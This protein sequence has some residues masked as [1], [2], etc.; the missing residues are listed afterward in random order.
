MARAFASDLTPFRASRGTNA[1]D[2]KA[3]VTLVAALFGLVAFSL[4]ALCAGRY[5]LTPDDVVRVLWRHTTGSVAAN[6]ADA[7]VWQIRLPRI[8]VAMLVGAALASAGTAYQHLFRN[9]LVAPDT[10]GV[11]SGAALGAVLGIFLGAGFLVIESA[12]FVGGLAGVGAVMIIAARLR[13]HDPIVTLILTG[14]VVASLLGA[15]ISI[16]KY[17][18]DPYNELPAITFWLMGSFASSSPAEATSLLPAVALALVVL[19]ALAWRINVL[20]LAE[21]EARA[22][23]IDA[24]RL[25]AVVVAAATLATAGSVAVS[26]II[27]WVGLVVPHM[28]RL[29]VGPEF[30]RLLPVAA[31]FG[32]AFMLLIDTI[33]RTIAPIEL[34]PGILTAVVG[35]PVFIALLARTRRVF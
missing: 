31:I 20:A 28:A 19:F 24:K 33:A 9:P 32:A 25:R 2:V 5:P 16:L 26:G 1:S 29:V 17:L 14:I 30:S 3:R 4:L 12:A 8:G 18:A 35:T 11:S 15:A 6:T 34:P 21:D 22:L 27:G 23:G 7:I 10:L 13:A